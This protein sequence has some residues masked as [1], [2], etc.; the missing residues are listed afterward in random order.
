MDEGYLFTAAPS[1][2]ER[3]VAH[4][5]PPA[6]GSSHSLEVELLLSGAAPDLGHGKEQSE[7]IPHVQYKRNTSKTVGVAREH[8]RADTL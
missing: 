4:L 1:D 2:L 8:Q 3:G 5:S 7:E 6:P